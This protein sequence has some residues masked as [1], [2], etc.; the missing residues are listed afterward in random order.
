MPDGSGQRQLGLFEHLDPLGCSLKTHVRLCCM[1]LTGLSLNWKEKGT[2]SSPKDG[3]GGIPLSV[4][5][6]TT[7][8]RP[9]D[10]SGYG[11]SRD[12]PTA[13][14]KGRGS[15]L[16]DK[17]AVA[18]WPTPRASENENRTTKHAPS[19]EAGTHGKTLAGTAAENWPTVHG[20]NG[21]NGPTG[22][23]LGYLVGQ[24]DEASPNTT[25]KPRGSLNSAWV[26]QLM[27]FPDEYAAELTRLLCE[28]S[29]TLGAT[30]TRS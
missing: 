2:S 13:V 1:D 25:G 6:L 3:T 29:E 28:W 15:R 22:T 11:S 14:A 30:R 19:H 5:V 7:L 9:T 21:T 12:W 20:K 17:A 8:E 24:Q 16:E 18:S 23:E 4:L 10:E 27:G 26:M